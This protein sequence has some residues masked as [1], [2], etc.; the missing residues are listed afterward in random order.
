MVYKKSLVEGK[1]LKRYKR[2]FAD[3][4]I[5]GEIVVAHV[6]NTGSMKTCIEEN[7]PCFLTHNPDP[8]RKLKW[9]LERLQIAKHLVGVNTGIPNNLVFEAWEN[10]VVPHWLDYDCAQK[11]V[12]INAE[13]RLD[14]AMW[15]SKDFPEI[16]KLTPQFLNELFSV[17]QTSSKMYSPTTQGK[18]HF[19]EIKN[20]TMAQ[21]TTALFP[22]AVTSR[23]TKHIE[24]LIKLMELGHSCEMVFVVQREGV[25][26]FDIARDIDPNYDQT[27]KAAVQKGLKVTALKVRFTDSETKVSG[28]F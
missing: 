28:I 22:D 9:T 1:F 5:N 19:I 18:I 3:V 11:E 2:F 4:E 26:Q 15:K 10:K 23:G 6:P 24:E 16:T 8:K 14:M 13:S 12:K 20:V 27:L 17:K 7:A 21:D 25:T